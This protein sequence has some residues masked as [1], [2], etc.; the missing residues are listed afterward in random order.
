MKF[1][2]SSG[3][4]S[5]VE[6]S[7]L[8]SGED[9]RVAVLE[10]Y[11]HAALENDPELT[12]ITGF[13][14]RLCGT[15]LAFVTIVER[16]RQ[17]FI[18]REG[19]ELEGTPRSESF[20]A[21][22]MLSGEEMVVPDATD[23]ARFIDNP[24]VT[25]DEHVR[26]YAG[27]PLISPEGASLGALCVIDRVA[28]PEGL[29]DLQSE[30]LR[31]LAQ[32]V[33]RRLDARRK[34][35]AAELRESEG[36]RTMRE[37]ADLLPAIIW[38]ADGDGNFDYFNSRWDQVTGEPQPKLTDDWRPVVHPDETDQAFGSWWESYEA[39]KPYESEYRLRQADGSWRW[40]LSRALAVADSSGKVSRWYG[41][42]TDID[43][44]HRL[45]DTRD[46]LAKELSHRIKNIFAV[47]AGLVSIRARRH[48]AARE[49]ADELVATIRALGRA[50]DFVR[51]VE[52]A[53]GD[54]LLG[55]MRD[56]MAPY[57][58]GHGRVSLTGRD[59]AIG[60]R[61][62]TPLALIF[63]ELA[64][65]SA[66]YGALSLEAGTVEIAIDCPDDD[67]RARITWRETG[68]PQLSEPGKEGF[69]SRLVQMSVEGQ[70]GGKIERR[71]LPG[72]IEI[73]LD[74]PVASI[75]T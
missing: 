56:L 32:A 17:S 68:G 45:S 28:R 1:E 3:P 19:A 64:T 65:N 70:L 44:S 71:F 60:T 31:V 39:G 18:A 5:S 34:G 10:A 2:E 7:A 51:P 75:R 57:D 58:D 16:D 21:H 29:T 38:S 8:L 14:A 54:S 48:E 66:K 49:F 24:L 62:A 43:D 35:L 13:A 9:E 26:F 22:T 67:G 42:L 33:M 47:V 4:P 50:H 59:C 46:L 61:A 27:S 53:K 63:H 15:P 72:G 30:G 36:Q 12:A 52:G 69:G 74:I 41:T 20:C 23:D 73:D 37:I 6:P 11:R 25:G 55:L 40:T